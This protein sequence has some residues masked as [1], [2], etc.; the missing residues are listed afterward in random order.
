MKS[1][2]LITESLEARLMLDGVGVGGPEH[3][4]FAIPDHAIEVAPGLFSLGSAIDSG[5]GKM[6]EGY[7]VATAKKEAA[8]P[9]GTPGNGAKGGGGGGGGD[10]TCYSYLAK[11]AKWKTTEDY[12][13]ST[14]NALGLGAEFIKDTVATSLDTWNSVVADDVFLGLNAD[15]TVDGA[16]SQSPDGKNEV[17]FADISSPGV[18]AVTTVWGIFGGPPGQRELVEWDTVFDNDGDFDFGDVEAG[19]PSGNI[20]FRSIATHEFGHS[21]GLAHPSDTCTEETMYA[22]YRSG[23]TKQRTLNAGD[24]A[25]ITGLYGASNVLT[26]IATTDA[27]VASIETGS[28]HAIPVPPEN[29]PPTG[30]P[31]FTAPP[32]Q[33]PPVLKVPDEAPPV[34]APPFSDHLVVSGQNAAGD[35]SDLFES[36]VDELMAEF[37]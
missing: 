32:D 16:D 35:D 22:Y 28:G 24:I 36:V 31:P 15:D 33:K 23:E 8:K 13:V 2:Q 4:A 12:L 27:S 18:I 3:G 34:V 29:H 21:A 11:G 5:S 37:A 14:T 1:R 19:S 25:G 6:V 9:P 26:S 17:L 10:S 7:L 20:D 30:A